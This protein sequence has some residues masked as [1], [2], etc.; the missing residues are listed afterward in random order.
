MWLITFNWFDGTHIYMY[1]KVYLMCFNFSHKYLIVTY[2]PDVLLIIVVLWFQ[3]D[4]WP[5]T[6]FVKKLQR[7]DNTFYYYNR[8]REC[9]DREVNKVKV[10]AYWQRWCHFLCFSFWNVVFGKLKMSCCLPNVN[11]WINKI[12]K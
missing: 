8:K 12:S 10:Y 3:I 4:R 7:R 5:D 6:G 9:E 2:S 1:I 11:F